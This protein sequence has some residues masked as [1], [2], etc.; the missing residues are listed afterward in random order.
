[1]E[2][3]RRGAPS[4]DAV[5]AAQAESG[6]QVSLGW[7]AGSVP[8]HTHACFY[9]ADENTLRGTLAFVRAGLDAPGEFNVIFADQSRH[10][11]LL[12]WLQDGYPGDVRASLAEGKLALVPGASTRGEL[13]AKIAAT[14]DGGLQRGHRLIRFLG[15]IAWGAPGWPDEAELLEFES[16]VNAAVAAYPAVVICTYGVPRLSGQQ[17]IHGGL[18]T[19]PVVFLNDRV[20]ENSPLFGDRGSANEESLRRTS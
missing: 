6:V 19:H 7:T 15:F 14:L 16:E 5:V 8:L 18:M 3:G 11:S 10:D 4:Y 20:L 9:Y 12:E 17:L 1:M 2:T 13:L